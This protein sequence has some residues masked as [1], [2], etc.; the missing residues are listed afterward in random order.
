MKQREVRLN[1]LAYT[2]VLTGLPNREMLVNKLDYLVE[3]S[4]EK[5]APFA[6]VFIDLDSFKKINDYKGHHIGDLLL[7]SIADRIKKSFYSRICSG[8]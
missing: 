8:V 4:Q 3:Q 5:Q 6:V 7:K 2:D 1:Y